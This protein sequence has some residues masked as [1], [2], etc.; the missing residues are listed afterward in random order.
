MHHIKFYKTMQPIKNQKLHF[1]L[2]TLS[3]LLIVIFMLLSCSFGK[4]IVLDQ[5]Q[6]GLQQTIKIDANG[7]LQVST[8]K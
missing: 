7:N 1:A 2:I 8:L 6:D 3:V 5:Q 4:T